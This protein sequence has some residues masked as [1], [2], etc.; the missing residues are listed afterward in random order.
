MKVLVNSDILANRLLSLE[1]EEGAAPTIAHTEAG[2]TPDFHSTRA[3]EADSVVDVNFSGKS[4]WR[5]EAGE[6]I[7]AGV[8]VQAG[9]DGVL[10]N[11]VESDIG[12]VTATV[13]EGEIATLVRTAGSIGGGEGEPG[14]Q[15]EQGP[16]GPRGTKGDKGDKGDPGESQFTAD[17]V[18]ALKA[19]I[20]E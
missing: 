13:E 11:A 3:I 17:E 15:G 14:P 8:R 1:S 19:L 10:I 18:T 7:V 5:I 2:G 20:Q 16:Q 4:T 6:A 9:E 12:Y